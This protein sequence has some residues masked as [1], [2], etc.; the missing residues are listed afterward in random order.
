MKLKFSLIRTLAFSFLLGGALISC[1]EA[2]Q[3]PVTPDEAKEFAKKLESS[4]EK[5]TLTS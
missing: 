4:I 1:K 3:K 5:E 2:E